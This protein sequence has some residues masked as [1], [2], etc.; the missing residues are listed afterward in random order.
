[1][2][3]KIKFL[4]FISVLCFTI[5][6]EK[7]NVSRADSKTNE[8]DIYHEKE[9]VLHGDDIS[10]I[11]DKVGIYTLCNERESIC[12][13]EEEQRV[14]DLKGSYLSHTYNEGIW[15][16]LIEDKDDKGEI[17]KSLVLFNTLNF[18]KEVIFIPFN[19][20][21]LVWYKDFLFIGGE[22]KNDAVIKKL[23][24]NATFTTY[25]IKGTAYEAFT[26]GIVFNDELYLAGIKDA[27]TKG[28]YYKNVGSANEQKAF[29]CKVS[30]KGAFSDFNFYNHDETLEKARFILNDK[31][32]Y[33]II[34]ADGNDYFYDYLTTP[35]YLF[36]LIEGEYIITYT[37][38]LMKIVK[39]R[40]KIKGIIQ[41][42]EIVLENEDITC[43]LI[44]NT[45][46]SFCVYYVCKGILY[47]DTITEYHFD[48][49]KPIE[50][51]LNTIGLDF[52]KDLNNT[53][54]FKISS[55]FYDVSLM[56][57]EID[58]Y[59]VKQ[60]S[61]KYH[62]TYEIILK[63]EGKNTFILEDDIIIKTSCNIIN[64][65][66][67]DTGITIRFLG[68]AELDGEKILNGHVIDDENEHLLVLENNLSDKT[69]IKFVTVNNYIG[70]T[71]ASIQAADYYVSN[72]N[73]KIIFN[74]TLDENEL[75]G[76]YALIN[77]EKYEIVKNQ[78][79]LEVNYPVTSEEETLR[80]VSIVTNNNTYEINKTINVK[81]LEK[82]PKL[83]FTE[84]KENHLSLSLDIEDVDQ[85]IKYYEVEIKVNNKVI[86]THRSYLKD[87][88]LN[89]K[90]GFKKYEGYLYYQD[91]H[92]EL[93]R[94]KIFEYE[95]DFKKE[96][97]SFI[98][99]K[100]ARN[101]R[102]Y[103]MTIDFDNDN[104]QIKK[105]NISV[106]GLD[107]SSK[108]QFEFDYKTVIIAVTLTVLLTAS[109]F[110][111]KYTIKKVKTKK[112]RKI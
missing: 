40:F 105:T 23:N 10:A 100:Y 12:I 5:F 104:Y 66:I 75:R 6:S 80:F 35:V 61:G 54:Y 17:T 18:K 31:K 52:T 74:I 15:Y 79:T 82:M 102:D 16:L 83:T 42:D 28:E 44:K 88:T 38:V 24:D 56:V 91:Q 39:D 81:K 106:N 21:F 26:A 33:V 51:D 9:L 109:V 98:K 64:G 85:T 71:T 103:K 13:Y 90:K 4:I 14:L 112:N 7:G 70:K 101:E 3:K 108:Y 78:D 48:I 50:L 20:H 57:K 43:Y 107:L 46:E 69:I 97:K 95:G 45:K 53:P 37:D 11:Y 36:K 99:L 30:D 1:M 73:F 76:A 65:G 94:I 68:K 67:Y 60:M 32:L 8:N 47:K 87:L 55:Y 62:A 96:I 41:D 58:P 63:K 72:D 2:M 77:D 49:Y 89:A 29:T 22:E 86:E 84:Q 25:V 19:A 93:K 92:Q 59:F 111:T 110:I 34:N 27:H